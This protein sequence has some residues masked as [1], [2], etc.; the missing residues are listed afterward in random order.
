[1]DPWMGCKL[2]CARQLS[3]SAT[4]SLPLSPSVLCVKSLPIWQAI[5]RHLSLRARQRKLPQA[6]VEMLLL[7][8]LL[9]FVAPK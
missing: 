7:L 6:I 9:M 5:A 3:M 4:L 8:L 2:E 1:M